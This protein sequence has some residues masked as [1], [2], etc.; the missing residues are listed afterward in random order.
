MA[1]KKL[2]GE[3][4]IVK[5]DKRTGGRDGAVK[6]SKCGPTERVVNLTGKAGNFFLG[7]LF[8]ICISFFISAKLFSFYFEFIR[9]V[10]V[11]SLVDVSDRP[12]CRGRRPGCARGLR[13]TRDCFVK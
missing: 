11:E 12:K 2:F 1:K 8:Y 5:K 7:C 10:S 13:R 9:C 6:G 3:M 4:R